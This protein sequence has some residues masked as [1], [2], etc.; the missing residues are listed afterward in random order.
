[1]ASSARWGARAAVGLGF[2][3]ASSFASSE[4]A[5]SSPADLVSFW[6]AKQAEHAWLEDVLGE[7][8]LAWVRA[9]NQKTIEALGDPTGTPMYERVLNILTSKDKIPVSHVS[10]PGRARA[11]CAQTQTER[12]SPRHGPLSRTIQ[13]HSLAL[14]L[15]SS[16]SRVRSPQYIGKI[17]DRYYNFWQDKTHKRG[18]LRR[19][20]LESYESGSPDWETVISVDALCEQEGES[21][22]YKGSTLLDEGEGIAPSRTLVHLSRGGAD[23]T[24]VREFDLVALRFVPSSEGGFELPEAKSSVGWQSRNVLLVGTDFGPGSLTES[25]YPRTVREWRRGTPLS[26][27]TLVY[28]GQATDVSVRGYCSRHGKY[29]AR[30][31]SSASADEKRARPAWA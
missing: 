12:L 6:E 13:P 26:D 23:A 3:A 7:R 18:I 1:V 27:S 21:W 8:A 9:H 30:A 24:V 11:R 20:T 15:F 10:R 2:A 25:G 29:V 4:Q 19:T 17:G 22:V 28:E 5:P 31:A 14:R 16:L